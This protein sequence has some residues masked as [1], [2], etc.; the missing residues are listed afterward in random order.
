MSAVT[1]ENDIA[2]QTADGTRVERLVDPADGVQRPARSSA[3]SAPTPTSGL[4]ATAT[5]RFEPA[6]PA[7]ARCPATQ[8]APAADGRCTNDAYVL[9]LDGRWRSPSGDYA[10]AWQAIGSALSRG[11]AAQR[12]RRHPHRARTDR[13]R[14]VALRRQGGGNL[15]LE[16]LAAPDR[17]PARVQRPRLPRAQE[18][19]PGL[20]QR[21][22]PDAAPLVGHARYD[23]RI[24]A[25]RAPDAGRRASCGAGSTLNT[26]WTLR[27]FW[28]FYVELNAARRVLRR[29]RD[30]RRLGAATRRPRVGAVGRP[31][32][33]SAP[34]RHRLRVAGTRRAARDR[35]GVAPSGQ[36]QPHAARSCRS[37][38]CRCCRPPAHDCGLRRYVGTDASL[39]VIGDDRR[40]PLRRAGRRPAPA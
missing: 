24:S 14:R 9:S 11:P 33:R 40:L 35:N 20:L 5:N 27:N 4:L 34:P 8:A 36:R 22:L 19:L 3:S 25:Q 16:R 17:A 30:G 31:L 38:S 26:N 7:G 18:R 13:R 39:A 15:A 2:V 12:A 6:L 10:S 28:S 1:G 32:D 23:D 37:W 21:G 29:S